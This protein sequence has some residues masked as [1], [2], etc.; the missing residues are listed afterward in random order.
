MS[1]VIK[2]IGSFFTSEG[3]LGKSERLGELDSTKSVYKCFFMLAWPAIAESMLTALTGFVD[4]AMV[5]T[6]GDA[7]IAAVGLTNQPRLL[8][9][10]LFTT[11][12]LGVLAVVSRKKGEGDRE[13]AN[14][15]NALLARDGAGSAMDGYGSDSGKLYGESCPGLRRFCGVPV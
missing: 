12:N 7:A 8:F 11:L 9:W 6:L 4:T 14:E 10:S 1:A 13:A 15:Q 2:R 3:M 5:G